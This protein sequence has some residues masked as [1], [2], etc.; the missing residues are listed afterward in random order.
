[1]EYVW[2]GD[3]DNNEYDHDNS[4]DYDC[5]DDDDDGDDDDDLGHPCVA[6]KGAKHS[7]KHWLQENIGTNNTI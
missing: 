3:E 2:L 5:D 1:M 4:D 7:P 6:W